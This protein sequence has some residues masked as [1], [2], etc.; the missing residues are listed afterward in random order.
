ML[1]ATDF[2]HQDA[3]AKCPA[4]V[5][6]AAQYN[7]MIKKLDTGLEKWTANLSHTQR[8]DVLDA[9]N[10]YHTNSLEAVKRNVEAQVQIGNCFLKGLGVPQATQ[11]AALWFDVAA[12][13]GDEDAKRLLDSLGP[14]DPS[15]GA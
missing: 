13:E 3:N 14:P 10:W 1:E 4:D 9:L 5:L 2:H 8:K 6:R 7:N 11:E 12:A 15:S